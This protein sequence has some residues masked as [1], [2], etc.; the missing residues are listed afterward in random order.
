MTTYY[1]DIETTG[2]DPE[3]DK[4]ITI[5]F[6]PRN[7][8][9]YNSLNKP[10]SFSWGNLVVLK[11]WESSEEDIV[12]KFH[13]MF[14]G[15]GVWDF[16]PLGTN[17]MFEFNFLFKKFKKYNLRCPEFL[18]YIYKKPSIDIRG[19]LLMSNNLNFKDSG[20][21]KFSEKKI[22]GSQVPG[23]YEKKDYDKIIDYINMETDSFKIF[24]DK[25]LNEFPN[26]IKKKVQHPCSRCGK[27]MNEDEYECLGHC[28][29][30]ED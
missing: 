14:F 6:L 20:L 27:E 7:I 3:L 2:T 17:L 24:V 4:I 28:M 18:D 30:C 1:L 16:I 21:E 23:W 19:I 26:I 11:E 5:Q 29:E 25:C 12:K 13:K 22:D 8:N 15:T 9:D 10:E